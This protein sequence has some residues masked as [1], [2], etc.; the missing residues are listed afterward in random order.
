MGRKP[1]PVG[2]ATTYIAAELRAQK[3]RLN[4]SLDK[5]AA[6]SGVPRSTV[7][8]AVKGNQAIPVEVLIAVATALGLNPGRLLDEA[9]TLGP[10][11]EE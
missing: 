11:P 2:P 10:R 9:T 5:I 4:W 7:N 3:G 6:K 8:T 1:G